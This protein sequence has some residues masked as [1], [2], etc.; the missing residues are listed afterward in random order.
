MKEKGLITD[1]Y[2]LDE[3]KDIPVLSIEYTVEQMNKWRQQILFAFL[4]QKGVTYS[5]K[6]FL[7]TPKRD[8]VQFSVNYVK[9]KLGVKMSDED[10]HV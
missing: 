4:K 10:V 9:S 8:L 6:K 1:D 3:H 2:W 7:K 5:L